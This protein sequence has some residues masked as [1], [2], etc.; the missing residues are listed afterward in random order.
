[1]APIPDT[2]ELQY[3]WTRHETWQMLF[4]GNWLRNSASCTLAIGTGVIA[5]L[6]YLKFTIGVCT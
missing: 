2:I 6:G 4:G 5:V 3:D 1:M